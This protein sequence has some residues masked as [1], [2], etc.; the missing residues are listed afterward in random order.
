VF[1]RAR[2]GPLSANDFRRS[3]SPAI[4]RLAARGPRGRSFRFC[5]QSEL[6]QTV[7][8][9]RAGRFRLGLPRI[10]RSTPS[11]R[12][13]FLQRRG[14]ATRNC[15]LPKQWL[16]RP[17]SIAAASWPRVV[18]EL[19]KTAET[20]PHLLG[21]FSRSPAHPVNAKTNNRTRILIRAVYAD[22]CMSSVE[23]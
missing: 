1:R 11:P 22:F 18:D 2:D 8:G 15:Q 21:A 12:A 3:S 20:A 17:I 6:D 16:L 10:H 9:L 5:L 19:D 4:D 23:S 14:A 7:D 13:G